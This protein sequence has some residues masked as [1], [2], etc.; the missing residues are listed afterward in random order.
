MEGTQVTTAERGHVVAVR[1]A[2]NLWS[3]VPHSKQCSAKLIQFL[4]H[5]SSRL[6]LNQ[7]CDLFWWVVK[8]VVVISCSCKEMKIENAYK[9]IVPLWGGSWRAVPLWPRDDCSELHSPGSLQQ[10][11]PCCMS[12]P[13]GAEVPSGVWCTNGAVLSTSMWPWDSLGA[14]APR[15][16]NWQPKG[17]SPQKARQEM[18][19]G[20][21]SR[22][23][24]PCSALSSSQKRYWSW[25][26][27]MASSWNISFL[28]SSSC[29]F[30]ALTWLIMSHSCWFT[31]FM[32]E[33]T[34]CQNGPL[35]PQMLLISL[36]FCDAQVL[37]WDSTNTGA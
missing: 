21:Q 8:S 30:S 12:W 22:A 27:S 28:D 5:A 35:C 11:G 7:W 19:Q 31:Y 4:D 3:A 36:P 37:Q 26:Q 29:A 33:D 13:R 2:G 32:L 23:D 9:K 14:A 34:S 15:C 25:K 10:A 24:P 16:Y 17:R 18:W 1:P 6:T 20:L